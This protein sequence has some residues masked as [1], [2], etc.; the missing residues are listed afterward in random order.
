LGSPARRADAHRT[1]A[2]SRR[3]PPR[4]PRLRAQQLE[5]LGAKVARRRAARREPALAR[6]V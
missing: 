6:F 3:R 1:C 4:A 2:P 5:L